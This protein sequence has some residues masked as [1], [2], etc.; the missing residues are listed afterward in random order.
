MRARTTWVFTAWSVV[1]A[2]CATHRYDVPETSVAAFN[3]RGGEESLCPAP[4]AI[5]GGPGGSVTTPSG[6]ISLGTTVTPDGTPRSAQ[7][8]ASQARPTSTGS[9]GGAVPTWWNS[10]PPVVI[11]NGPSP[12]IGGGGGGFTIPPP[13]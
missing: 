9:T 5:G 7:P 4:Q 8:S 13:R 2:A 12:T 11:E 6:S 10:P 3:A 1:A